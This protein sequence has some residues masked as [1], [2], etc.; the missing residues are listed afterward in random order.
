MAV[1]HPRDLFLYELSAMR[2]AERTG[3]LLLGSLIGGRVQNAALEKTLRAQAK[4]SEHQLD[5]INSCFRTL[6][7]TTTETPST[8]VEGVRAGFETFISLEPSPPVRDLFAIG[9][10]LRFTYFAIANYRSL[11]GWAV[12]MEE[13]QCARALQTNLFQKEESAGALERIGHEMGEKLF[14]PESAGHRQAEADGDRR[15]RARRGD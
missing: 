12:L 4:D 14:P 10:A 2:D 15:G 5:N 3:G 13:S 11:V 7:L 1:K 9:T 6:G 8:T